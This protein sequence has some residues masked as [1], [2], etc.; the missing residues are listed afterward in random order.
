MKKDELRVIITGGRNFRNYPMLE[1]RVNKILS[2]VKETKDIIIVSGGSKGAEHL[3]E[4]YARKNHFKLEKYPVEWD[5]YG[6]RAGAVRD[7]EML[8]KSRVCICFW[9][10]RNK[11]TKYFINSAKKEGLV[12]KVIKY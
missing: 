1:K 7:K 6:G 2:K 5:I 8:S 3:G 11:G 12:L 4:K 10:W 9:D